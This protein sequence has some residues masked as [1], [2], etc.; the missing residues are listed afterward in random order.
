M[1]AGIKIAFHMH[2]DNCP[3]VL[4]FFHHCYSTIWLEY[5]VVVDHHS[6][7]VLY[8]K[9]CEYAHSFDNRGSER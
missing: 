2:N 7:C 3:T 9:Y 5:P 8:K 6:L 1:I 4:K